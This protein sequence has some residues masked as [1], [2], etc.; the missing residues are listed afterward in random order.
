MITTERKPCH[1]CVSQGPVLGPLLFNLY[2]NDLKD[3]DP[4]DLVD[5]CQYT[6]DT[7]QYEHFKISQIRQIIQNTQKHLNNLNV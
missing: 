4:A 2:V 1:F 3:I 5:T 6:D 7:T